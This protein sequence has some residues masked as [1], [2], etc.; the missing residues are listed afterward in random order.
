[1]WNTGEWPDANLQVVVGRIVELEGA[2][3]AML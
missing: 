3:R 2:K 1:M